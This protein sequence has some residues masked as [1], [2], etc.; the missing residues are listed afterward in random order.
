MSLTGC[1]SSVS[2]RKDRI[3]CFPLMLWRFVI[4]KKW[5]RKQCTSTRS[6]IIWCELFA[7]KLNIWTIISKLNEKWGGR[8]IHTHIKRHMLARH[9]TGS[10]DGWQTGKN[11]Y[12]GRTD[13]N[14]WT[15]Y[16]CAFCVYF[17]VCVYVCVCVCVCVCVYEYIFKCVHIIICMYSSHSQTCLL[18]EC[19]LI[20]L[21][22]SGA[23]ARHELGYGTE[24]GD[25]KPVRSYVTQS[26]KQHAN[27]TTSP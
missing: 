5:G 4:K 16:M 24:M 23:M 18:T 12:T 8:H 10:T 13:W 22:W 21:A 26:T 27:I 14:V 2:E 25:L 1:V 15:S 20:L 7:C 3:L 19:I 11:F 6:W 17:P 9:K